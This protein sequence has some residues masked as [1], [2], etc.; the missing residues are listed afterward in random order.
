[1]LST[2]DYFLFTILTDGEEEEDL[3]SERFAGFCLFFGIFH[4][5]FKVVYL[6][7]GPMRLALLTVQQSCSTSSQ[8]L[9]SI[10]K[11]ISTIHGIQYC[12]TNI[13]WVVVVVNNFGRYNNNKVYYCLSHDVVT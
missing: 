5:D 4:F 11:F 3:L 1:M 6:S 8:F 13:K 10:N 9:Y 2:N 12:K 7:G